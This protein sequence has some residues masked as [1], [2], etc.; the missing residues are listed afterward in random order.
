MKY[1]QQMIDSEQSKKGVLAQIFENSD[2]DNL[3]WLEGIKIPVKVREP[4][5]YNLLT[6]SSKKYFFNK[7]DYMESDLGQPVV[8]PRLLSVLDSISNKIQKYKAQLYY[9]NKPLS[10]NHFAIN[11]E[12]AYDCMNLVRSEYSKSDISGKETIFVVRKLIL[13]KEK[14][15]QI[16]QDEHLFRLKEFTPVTI[17]DEYGKNLIEEAGVVGVEFQELEV[18][19]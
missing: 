8:T 17:I 11:L 3:P 14:L 19:E 5:Q 16:P 15:S 6:S 2:W 7:A 12:S 13:S 4:L 1:Y 9:Q 10:E 18:A